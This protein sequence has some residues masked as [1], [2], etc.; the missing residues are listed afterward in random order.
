MSVALRSVARPEKHMALKIQQARPNRFTIRVGTMLLA[1]GSLA[2]AAESRPANPAFAIPSPVRTVMENYCTSCHEDGTSKGDVR[3]D[4]LE[5]LALDARLEL[6]NRVHEQVYLGEMP[7]KKKDQPTEAERNLLVGWVAKEL[8]AHNASKLEDKL[9]MPEY[10]NVVDHE[11]L[12]S[13]KY[14]D[15]PG[16]TPDRRW[17]ISEF[18]FD[19]KF[20]KLLDVT[21]SRDIDGKRYPVIGDNNRNG[22][23]L[24]NPFL[25]PTHSGVRYYDTTSLDGGHFLTMITNAK[26][27]S[28]RLLWLTQRKNYI[29]AIAKIMAAEWEHEKILAAREAYLIANVEPLLRELYQGKHEAMLPRFVPSKPEPA[30]EAPC[31]IRRSPPMRSWTRSTRPC[32]GTRRMARRTRR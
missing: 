26:E 28:G 24:T 3:L 23:N 22:V 5:S 30:P 2:G 4:N 10:G 31:S 9:R 6:L 19:A 16:F 15:L 14:K 1:L 11:K 7:P 12:F 8:Q 13:G 25:L 17:L 27:A 18:I 21:P 20:N 29:P 32:C